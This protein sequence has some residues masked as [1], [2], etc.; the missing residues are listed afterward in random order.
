MAVLNNSVIN[1]SQLKSLKDRIYYGTNS[2]DLNYLGYDHTDPDSSIIKKRDEA[3]VN[4]VLFWLSSKKDDYIRESLK[5]GVLYSL[6]G[7]LCNTTNLTE[8]EQTITVQF[9][10]AFANDMSLMYIKLYSD[11]AYRKIIVTMVVKDLVDESV[12]TVSTEA[13]K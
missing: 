8:W 13:S 1:D 7:V 12:F 11:K 4:R 6:L 2:I 3:N 10:S 9:N 5:G